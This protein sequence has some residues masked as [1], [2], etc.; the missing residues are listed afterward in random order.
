MSDNDSASAPADSEN[1]KKGVDEQPV[2]SEKKP[3][4][5]D[6]V[7]AYWTEERMQRALPL[8]M[9]TEPDEGDVEVS[10]EVEVA[11]DNEKPTDDSEGDSS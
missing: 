5:H 11:A 7:L 1:I 10:E 2:A 6:E 8:E 4:S 3:R 9:A